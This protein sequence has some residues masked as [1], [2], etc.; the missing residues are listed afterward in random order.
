MAMLYYRDF[1]HERCRCGCPWEGYE[2]WGAAREWR[3]NYWRAAVEDKGHVHHETAWFHLEC[4]IQGRAGNL[5]REFLQMAKRDGRN[6]D[7]YNIIPNTL[8]D[9]IELLYSDGG[10]IDEFECTLCMDSTDEG[11]RCYRNH[12]DPTKRRGCETN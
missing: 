10:A 9:M 4:Y 2:T 6:D 8:E 7:H 3:R 12:P 11:D 1:T 5:L